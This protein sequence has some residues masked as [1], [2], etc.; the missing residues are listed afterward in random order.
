LFVAHRICMI[1]HTFINTIC[2]LPKGSAQFFKRSSA[3]GLIMIIILLLFSWKN[4]SK[5]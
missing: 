1:F 4:G 5:R 3:L 2:L